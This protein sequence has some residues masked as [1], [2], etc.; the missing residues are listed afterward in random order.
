METIAD[1][2]YAH[3]KN[4]AEDKVVEIQWKSVTKLSLEEYQNALTL[5]LDFQTE[6]PNKV[7]FYLSDIREQKILSP[8]FRKWFQEVAIPRALKNNL[9][10]GA[11][12]FD[13]NVFKKY[14]LNNIMNSTKKFGIPF[15]FFNTREDAIIWLKSL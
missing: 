13:G 8:D 4:Y 3:I 10:A 11:V 12:I 15:K 2:E 7:D 6:N 1:L 9:K 5:A 14:Y